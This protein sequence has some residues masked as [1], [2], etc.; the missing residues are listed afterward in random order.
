MHHLELLTEAGFAARLGISTT[1]LRKR[2]D[3]PAPILLGG[4]KLW[5]LSDVAHLLRPEEYSDLVT[6]D[7]L[8]A[9]LHC[10]IG[11]VYRWVQQGMLPRSRKARWSRQDVEQHLR[12][13]PRKARHAA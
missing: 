13:L 5:F 12:A 3:I 11:T 1:T 7:E 2:R 9:L 8:A 6:G 4:R 10:C